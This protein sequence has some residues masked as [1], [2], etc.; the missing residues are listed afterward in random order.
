MTREGSWRT[1]AQLPSL[2][3]VGALVLFALNWYNN[4]SVRPTSSVITVEHTEN[5]GLADDSILVSNASLIRREDFTCS[6]SAPCS[7]G[8]CCGAS[9]YCGYG[10]TYCGAGCL[11]QCDA[12]AECGQYASDPGKKCLLNVCCSQYGMFLDGKPW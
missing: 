7:N 5:S 12:T 6:A 2:L 1:G 8:A 3:A 10:P 9:G 4:P 11:S